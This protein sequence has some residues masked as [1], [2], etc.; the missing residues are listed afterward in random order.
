M[1]QGHRRN[2][3]L[4]FVH[5]PSSRTFDWGEC[6]LLKF[7]HRTGCNGKVSMPSIVSLP[8]GHVGRLPHSSGAWLSIRHQPFQSFVSKALKLK[9]KK[10]DLYICYE[11]FFASTAR[12]AASLCVTFRWGLRHEAAGHCLPLA[13]GRHDTPWSVKHSV[14]YI[15]IKPVPQSYFPVFHQD[16]KQPRTDHQIPYTSAS[17]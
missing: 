8:A 3:S 11:L 2:V 16:S 13:P 17:I 14:M 7:S 10:A 6:D 15:G 12:G 9:T 1:L 5:G 4:L